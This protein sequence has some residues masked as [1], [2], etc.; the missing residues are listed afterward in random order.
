[1]QYRAKLQHL[2]KSS[3]CVLEVGSENFDKFLNLLGDSIT[4][5]GWAGYRGGLDTKSKRADVC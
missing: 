5:Q 2:A 3:F 1:M 4:L